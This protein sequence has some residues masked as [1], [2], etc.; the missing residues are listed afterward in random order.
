VELEQAG[1]YLLW[2]SA[3]AVTL[4]VLAGLV[5]V[6]R[7]R[8]LARRRKAQA[9]TWDCG[10]A[11]PTVRMQYSAS[12]FAQP[13]T[14]LFQAILR[15]KKTVHVPQAYFPKSA[16]LETETPDMGREGVY[17]PIFALVKQFLGR[18]TILQHG[19]IQI[20]VLYVVITLVVLLI[21]QLR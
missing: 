12:S 20:Y 4:L 11:A 14:D 7:L 19:R 16:H 2:I 15:T 18:F 5:A 9:V 13:I 10:Y 8:L 17:Q 21:W 6:I 3:G 1:G